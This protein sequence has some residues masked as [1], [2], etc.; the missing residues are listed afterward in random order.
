[1]L[2]KTNCILKIGKIYR[3]ISIFGEGLYYYDFNPNI[4]LSIM[5]KG[6]VVPLCDNDILLILEKIPG[7][8]NV[9]K[10]LLSDKIVYIKIDG[11]NPFIGIPL[12]E[13]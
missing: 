2:T 12:I 13:I 10:V 6:K 1:M 5:V 7:I 4:E 8:Y 3:H 9:Y 11:I